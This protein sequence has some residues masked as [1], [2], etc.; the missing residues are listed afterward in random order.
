MNAPAF[1][2]PDQFAVTRTLTD[3][4]GSWLVL[5]FYP[6]DDTPGCTT[7]ACGFRDYAAAL[8]K[9]GAQVVGISKDSVAS[10]KKFAEK[11]SLNFPLLSDRSA[12]TIQAYGAWGKKRFMGREYDG[13]RR[14]TFLISPSGEIVQEYAE[15]TPATHAGQIIQDL[16][17]LRA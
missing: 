4:Q 15:V 12:E 7:E 5:Y 3:F 2:L 10:H 9:M 8:K 6:K 14:M 13:I 11:Y 17:E 1:S 16:K